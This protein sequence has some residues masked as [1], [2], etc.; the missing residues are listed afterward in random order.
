M[1][2][3]AG[4]LLTGG[5]GFV[6]RGVVR[7]LGGS[8][9]SSSPDS[10][11]W[12]NAD[13]WRT[14]DRRT[15]RLLV[16]RSDPPVP[17]SAWT[18]EQVSGDLAHPQSLA[19]AC[20]GIHTVLHLAS[21]I[22]DDPESCERVNGRGTEALVETAI[23]AGVRRI[24][25]VSSAAVYGWAVHRGAREEDVTVAPA[26]PVSRSR[27]R[28]ERAVLAA[29]GIVLRP[30]FVYGEGDMRFVP[31]VIGAVR[32]LPFLV[33]HGRA[34]ISVVCVDDLAAAIL[35]VAGLPESKWSSRV[36]HVTDGR[37][38][39]FSELVRCLSRALDLSVPRRS[40]PYGVARLLVRWRGGGLT[41]AGRSSASAAHR[42]FLVSRDHYYD[43]SAI[44]RLTG[45]R[46]G[47]P[48]TERV[49]E[50]TR[51]YGGAGARASGR[52]PGDTARAGAVPGSA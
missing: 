5:S 25:Y 51:W 37:P 50:V 6:G 12:D 23:A 10:P 36:L 17:A 11:T 29:G 27:A 9:P 44:G 20:D 33:D 52:A 22:S 48:L 40:V 38:I 41:G 26:T 47:P 15:L 21:H 19:G 13:V 16:H 18:V 1:S 46:P 14:D 49:D 4:I 30:L 32:R 39:T 7:S 28:A 43:S 24:V 35:A 3:P 31:T 45:L 34:R 2:P 42:L 8:R